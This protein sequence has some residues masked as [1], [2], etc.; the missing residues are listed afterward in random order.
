[1]C[2]QGTAGADTGGTRP[3]VPL[4]GVPALVTVPV[5][6]GG[7]GD[8][9]AACASLASLPRLLGEELITNLASK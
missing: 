8:P 7:T 6:R 3:H 4:L 1:M 9:W 2:L 5:G